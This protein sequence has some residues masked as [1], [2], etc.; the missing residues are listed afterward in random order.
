MSLIYSNVCLTKR[1]KGVRKT[2]I[3]EMRGS[4]KFFNFSIK[5]SL[6]K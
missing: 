4:N 3:Q 6:Q 2:R 5:D 1:E